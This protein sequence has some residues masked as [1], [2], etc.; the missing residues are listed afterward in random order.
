VCARDP[1]DSYT[2]DTSRRPPQSEHNIEPY[3]PTPASLDRPLRQRSSAHWRRQ[4]LSHFIALTSALGR[5][6]RRLSG[7][8]TASRS[9][10]PG[11]RHSL[12]RL[13]GSAR[14]GVRLGSCVEPACFRCRFRFG[15]RA[16]PPQ[17]PPASWLTKTTRAL[18]GSGI[19]TSIRRVSTSTVAPST[20]CP[21]PAA[22]SQASEAF[23]AS[24]RP[25]SRWVS[26]AHDPRPVPA[27]PPAASLRP[28][29]SAAVSR[30]SLPD[31]LARRASDP[32][33]ATPPRRA[34]AHAGT[35]THHPAPVAGPSGSGGVGARR[36]E[37]G[38]RQARR[39]GSAGEALELLRRGP[40]GTPY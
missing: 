29:R 20:P 32:G 28:P 21:L 25:A 37:G 36:R 12:S 1:P 22:D 18:W 31:P 11:Q 26:A 15:T 16:P 10:L 5:R 17:G 27:A 7:P 33:L 4:P 9:R 38:E 39:L 35:P 13:P 6:P 40:V 19:S 30:A 34:Q 14:C 8:R 2:L 24:A 3:P 23:P